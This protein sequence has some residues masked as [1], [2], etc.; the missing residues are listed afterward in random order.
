MSKV[1]LSHEQQK[2][3]IA[4]VAAQN[5]TLH[6]GTMKHPLQPIEMTNGTPRFKRNAIVDFLVMKFGLNKLAAMDFSNEDWE[7]LTQLIGYSLS[8]F[9]ELSYV[10]DEAYETAA[11]M[12][13]EGKSEAEARIEYLEETL[14]AVRNGLKMIVP[15]VFRIHED[16]LAV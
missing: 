9:S 1:L 2:K 8:G 16:D 15:K 5:K 13:E 10:T 4:L 3:A 14:D 11:K 7:Q 12:H 6:G